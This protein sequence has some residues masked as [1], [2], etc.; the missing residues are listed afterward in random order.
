MLT[1]DPVTKVMSVETLF[2]IDERKGYGTNQLTFAAR[3]DV[4]P[5]MVKILH[6]AILNLPA[7]ELYKKCLWDI[8][9]EPLPDAFLYRA[10]T[11]GIVYEC[12]RLRA[13]VDASPV[14]ATR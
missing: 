4:M 14:D 10:D 8:V 13:P 5:G 6:V 3:D 9:E 7:R 1:C 12:R 11:D 2:A